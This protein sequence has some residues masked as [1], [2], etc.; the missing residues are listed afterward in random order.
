MR[1]IVECVPNF[2]EGRR[3][4]VVKAIADAI[5]SVRGTR[6]LDIQS[7]FD[8]NRSVITFVGSP[9]VV[10]EAAF[11][12]AA[13]AAELIDLNQHRGEHPRMGATDVVP[14][15]P[16]AGV[17]MEECVAIAR[18]VSERIGHELGIPVY[19][20]EEAATRPSR[21]NL[22]DIRHGEYEGIKAEIETNLDRAPDFG[23]SRLGPAGATAVGA[24]APLIAYN[25]NLA[26]DDLRVAQA[27]ARAV[28]HSS[29]GLRYVKALGFEIKERGIVQVSMN[30]TDYCQT[31]VF[32]VFDMVKREAA[33]YG[34]NVL[35]SELVGLT[36]VGALIDAADFY[37][38]FENLS[39]SQVLE[40]RLADE[41]AAAK[42]PDPFL[43]AVA[44][45]SAA[46]GGGSVSALAGALAV[47]LAAMVARLTIGKKRF[48]PVEAEMREL[49]RRADALRAELA[50]LIEDDEAAFAQVMAAYGLPKVTDAEVT[51]RRE[52]IQAAL[53]HASQVP[54]QVADRVLAVLELVQVV[55]ERGNPN[56]ASD[57]GV[58]A[59]MARAA[60]HGAALNVR[61]NLNYLEDRELA[62]RLRKEIDALV[63]RAE[64]LL[65]EILTSLSL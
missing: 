48:A 31:P 36:P 6:I 32:R 4:E 27:I 25:V 42:T 14:F 38:Q 18:R 55:A 1:Q 33:R 40:L 19:L 62:D 57:A 59:H 34:V 41:E 54:L 7:D 30:L 12:A 21:R 17:T 53:H 26:T 61:T 16:I 45:G 49:V 2:S 46:P 8:H 5:R 60:V 39:L 35:G 65:P 58:A 11:R 15:V 22:A 44:S 28:R 63:S 13:R 10:E 20:Y 51:A 52:A 50:G 64:N 3:P 23:P 43:E 47:A 9:A 56:A 29:G 24:R 37:L